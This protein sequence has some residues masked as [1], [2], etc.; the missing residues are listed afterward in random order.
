MD[1]ILNMD[2]ECSSSEFC[3]SN[4]KHVITEKLGIVNNIKL[5]KL[6]SEGRNYREKRTTSFNKAKKDVIFSKNNHFDNLKSKYKLD[7]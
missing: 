4:H 1:D 6:L 5:R 3:D 2:C 7:D